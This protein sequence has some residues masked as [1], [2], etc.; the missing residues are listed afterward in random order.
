MYRPIPDERDNTLTNNASES[1]VRS[2]EIC[3]G[4]DSVTTRNIEKGYNNN[5][6]VYFE[7]I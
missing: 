6:K 7:D 3:I 1:K 5:E 4:Q 2:T